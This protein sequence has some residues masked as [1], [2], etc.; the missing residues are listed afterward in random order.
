MASKEL[1]SS[2]SIPIT[3]EALVITVWAILITEGH[4][5]QDPSFL[6]QLLSATSEQNKMRSPGD[7]FHLQNRDGDIS[8]HLPASAK[9]VVANS[10]GAISSNELCWSV[11]PIPTPV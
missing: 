5:I 3:V 6:L 9:T 4:V 2:L 8:R 10:Y 7:R 1:E 11:L